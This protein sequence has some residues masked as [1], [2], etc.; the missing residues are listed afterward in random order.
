M[1]VRT[2]G[3]GGESSN[4]T[5]ASGGSYTAV[6]QPQFCAPASADPNCEGI[7]LKIERTDRASTLQA[8][9]STRQDG[10]GNSGV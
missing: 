8:E 4:T 6:Y 10:S 3:P 1:V 7:S 9:Y 2:A 5:V